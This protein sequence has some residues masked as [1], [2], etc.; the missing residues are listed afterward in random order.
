M[1]ALRI[2]QARAALGEVGA[3]PAAPAKSGKVFRKGGG[4]VTA[5][6]GIAGP[7][8]VS[9]TVPPQPA[10]P[11]GDVG[12][13]SSKDVR[14]GARKDV[15]EGPAKVA[16]SWGSPGIRGPTTRCSG[17]RREARARDAGAQ[18]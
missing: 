9:P 16:N 4:S 5:T 10:A 2:S 17:A 18:W 8:G 11:D 6:P 13:A 15:P 14:E 12:E 1:E 7:A 3:A